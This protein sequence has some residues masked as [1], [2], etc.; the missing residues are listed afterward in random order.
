MLATENTGAHPTPSRWFYLDD[1]GTQQGPFEQEQ[2]QAWLSGGH[3]T[4]ERLV[5]KESGAAGAVFAAA[6]DY[7]E[8][9]SHS[10]AQVTA[11][12]I[13]MSSDDDTLCNR[14]LVEVR[15]EGAVHNCALTAVSIPELHTSL[16]AQLGLPPDTYITVTEW[17]ELM[18]DFVAIFDAASIGSGCLLNVQ[19]ALGSRS[20]GTN[21]ASKTKPLDSAMVPNP[22]FSMANGAFVGEQTSPSAPQLLISANTIESDPVVSPRR[23]TADAELD[24]VRAEAQ[25]ARAKLAK[26][27]ADADVARRERIDREAEAAVASKLL[28]VQ[29]DDPDGI[30]TEPAIDSDSVDVAPHPTSSPPKFA[31]SEGS[32]KF[33][34]IATSPINGN[35]G[36]P[37]A[38]N[39]GDRP[40]T[41]SPPPRSQRP[42]TRKKTTRSVGFAMPEPDVSE[43]DSESGGSDDESAKSALAVGTNLKASSPAS[44][45]SRDDGEVTLSKL[46]KALASW[47][48][49]RLSDGTPR[50][51][52]QKLVG[53]GGSGAVFKAQDMRA[54]HP[55]AIKVVQPS[56]G[57]IKS[58]TKSQRRQMRREAEAMKEIH[59]D[60]VCECLEYTFVMS[61]GRCSKHADQPGK[62]SLFVMILEYLDGKTV[63]Q[64]M[65]ESPTGRLSEPQS[66]GC[67][68]AVLHG[69]QRVHEM[70]LVHRD[71]KP[72]NLMRIMINDNP[73]YKIID[74][75]LVSADK[76]AETWLVA[77]AT[78]R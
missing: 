66:V 38:P 72:D 69:L 26:L 52:I 31:S 55:V 68:L 51:I 15:Y 70:G 47:D 35:D 45:R 56:V 46:R 24:Q 43:D 29:I 21:A 53:V 64:L 17:D 48:E 58:F 3:I 27:R 39:D 76:S 8:L 71:L 13:G 36:G 9:A 10:T 22:V 6:K 73:V 78:V 50:W 62:C 28:T 12:A 37:C 33:A 67:A 14:G 61:K 41:P 2:F 16:R 7:P 75:G 60:N 11:I 32:T 57:G 44:P 42:L 63:R 23:A 34:A 4:L 18:D 5:K 40:R 59:N 1:A 77:K 49:G 30:D 65:D 25:I 54:K 74:F 20:E 19:R